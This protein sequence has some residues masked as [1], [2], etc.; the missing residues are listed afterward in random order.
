ME[1]ISED[2][3][4]VVTRGSC[5]ENHKW[6]VVYFISPNCDGTCAH[7]WSSKTFLGRVMPL[8]WHENFWKK[9][10]RDKVREIRITG[11]EP[12]LYKDLGKVTHI[13][14]KYLGDNIPIIILTSGR[15]FVSLDVGEDGI[16]E[17]FN[18]LTKL[19]LA[20]NNLEIHMSADEHHSGALLRKIHKN[21]NIPSSFYNIK[22]MNALG[23]APMV[24]MS[25]NFLG[26]C[27]L[28]TERF[29]LFKGG[30]LKIHTDRNRLVYHR[31]EMFDW[32]SDVDWAKKVVCSE[33]LIRSG[34]AA[35]NITGSVEI[36]QSKQIS[37][38]IF[39]GA[40]FFVEPKTKKAQRYLGEEGDF[41][42]DCSENENAAFIIGW[43]NVINK[44]RGK[45][46]ITDIFSLL[47][48]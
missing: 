9:I 27:D 32:I 43:W 41:Y 21:K 4:G 23:T 17:T 5:D 45:E 24:T 44:I 1:K 14:R 31:H 19:G 15:Q 35:R 26:A 34:S 30:K 2:E 25:K 3:G 29:N 40:E 10:S 48:I 47:G 39:P 36:K 8:S 18:N 13:I 20:M 16:R 6:E 22:R 12:F 11:G 7:C 37:L 33:G 42:L 46:S 38:F 28:L